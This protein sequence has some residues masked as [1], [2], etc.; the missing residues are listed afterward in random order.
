[1]RLEV[2]IGGEHLRAD[3]LFLEYRHEVE[4]VFRV[5]IADV[6]DLVRR[7]RETVFAV[8]LFGGVLHHAHDAFDNV[9]DVGKVAL[10]LA[11]VENLDGLAGLE[12][13]GEAEVGHVRAACGAIDGKEAEAGARDVVELAV[14]VGHELVA[15]LGGGVQRDWIVDLVVGGI[16][17]LLVAAVHAGGARVHE[18]LDFV[19]AACFQDV[20]ESDEVALDVGIRVRD[21]IADASLGGEVHDDGEV[22]LLEQAVDGGLVGEVRF[23]ECPLFAGR[24]RES[25]DFLEAL[26]L[27]VHVVVVGDAVEPDEFRAVVFGEQLLAEVAADESGGSGDEDCLSVEVDVLIQHRVP[28]AAD[29][30]VF[31]SRFGEFLCVV[32]VAAV[33]DE[34]VLHGLLHH[35]E[36]R[37]AELLPFGDEQ[38]CVGIE[39][40]FVHVV[41][42]DDLFCDCRGIR[43]CCHTALAFVHGDRVIDADCCACLGQEVDE[44]EGGGF[45]HVVSFGLEGET[46]HGNGLAFEVGFAAK[47]LGEL[48]EKHRL[49]VFVHFFD[50]LENAHLVAVLFGG[51]DEGLHVLRET[52]S[53]VAAA[54]VEELRADAGVATDALTDHVH[55]GAHE[56]AEVR[57]VVHEADAGCEHGVCSVLDHFGARDVRENHAEVVEHHRAV[58]AGH[59][60]FCLFAFHADDNAVGFHEVRDGGAFLQEFWVACDVERDVHATFVE[61]FLDGCL[62]L[63]GGADRDGRLGHE[64]GVLLD[65]LAERAGHG[66]HVLQVGGAVFVGGRA[67]GAEY[68]FDIVEDA[69]EVGREV[70]ASF[71][72]VTE[73]HFVETRFIYGN[74]AFLERFNF[75]LVHIDACHIDAHFGKT[76]A[77]YKAYITGSNNRNIHKI[78]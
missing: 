33:D 10:A 57:D 53:T 14:G 15:L 67:H 58:E 75:S 7:E 17:N 29:G 65:V 19:V 56:F 52:A 50:G 72:L 30:A 71:A 62:D 37:H 41:A 12:L 47:T 16:R 69:G 45:T 34:G 42:V 38:Q 27:D 22:V 25:F 31:E 20:V 4:Q 39:E 78:P 23:D 13:V 9:I 35:A 11:V 36:T 3:E 48:V 76:C 54:R 21:G 59:E 60:F 44:H 32:D 66:E 8:L 2:V 46:P 18:V 28:L 68:H 61:F 70:E 63:L 55:V 51:L 40:C 74:F 77:A 49:L 43:A 6:V 24:C 26:V 5:V 64:N 1:M 73:H